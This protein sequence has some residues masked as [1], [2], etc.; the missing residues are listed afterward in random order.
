LVHGKDDGIFSH[1]LASMS[2]AK[3]RKKGLDH[4]KFISE[5]GMILQDTV[6]FR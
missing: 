1:D 2:Y 6:C 4:I 5:E 3:L